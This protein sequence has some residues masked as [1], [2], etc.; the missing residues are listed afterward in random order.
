M[1]HQLDPTS[2]WPLLSKTQCRALQRSTVSPQLKPDRLNNH[3][4]HQNFLKLHQII[5]LHF[6]RVRDVKGFK[7]KKSICCC[8]S[9]KWWRRS[10]SWLLVFSSLSNRDVKLLAP[11]GSR[12][13]LWLLSHR[14]AVDQ[15]RQ[16]EIV[17]VVRHGDLFQHQEKL[18]WGV[19]SFG[20]FKFLQLVN[21]RRG[22]DCNSLINCWRKNML[23]VDS[24]S[25]LLE[26]QPTILTFLG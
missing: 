25:G 9:V 15:A 6:T 24:I 18:N 19:H 11:T 22:M 23:S 8:L 26:Y 10:F 1:F 21:H 17:Q 13:S 2:S 7:L 12:S 4:R 20:N 5:L 3:K 14:G 16:L